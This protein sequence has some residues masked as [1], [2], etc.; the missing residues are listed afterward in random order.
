MAKDRTARSGVGAISAG[1]KE[2][3][4]QGLVLSLADVELDATTLPLMGALAQN[5]ALQLIELGESPDAAVRLLAAQ[6]YVQLWSAR[7]DIDDSRALRDCIVRVDQCFEGAFAVAD[8]TRLDWRSNRPEFVQAYLRAREKEKRGK[9]RRSFRGLRISETK[10]AVS[11]VGLSPEDARSVLSEYET[12]KALVGGISTRLDQPEDNPHT[13]DVPQGLLDAI[14]HLKLALLTAGCSPAQADRAI[15]AMQEAV[16]GEPVGK[17]PFLDPITPPS[18]NLQDREDALWDIALNRE[19]VS[20]DE[21]GR[22]LSALGQMYRVAAREA[23]QDHDTSPKRRGRRP[24]SSE[25]DLLE[26]IINTDLDQD[27]RHRAVK[28]LNS[29]WL[30]LAEKS[31]K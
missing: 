16:A 14:P 23:S 21:R 7:R 27:T 11:E 9:P 1:R 19:G 5:A 12:F 20:L 3:S 29:R 28:T 26:I 31:R 8:L 6:R 18:A 4:A 15:A 22:A 24:E 25:D 2:R 17:G 10:Q 30:R 13:H